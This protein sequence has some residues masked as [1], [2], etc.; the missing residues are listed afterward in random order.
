MPFVAQENQRAPGPRLSFRLPG[1]KSARLSLVDQA[2]VSGSNFLTTIILVRALGLSLF[3]QFS[4]LWLVVIFFVALQQA[5]LGQPLLTFAPKQDP[6]ER[7]A[8][9]AST[10]RLSLMFS[11]L[12]A[13]VTI[14]GYGFYLSRWG[15]PV[16]DGTF[17]PMVLLVTARQAHAYLRSACFACGLRERAFWNDLVTY[18][19]QPLVLA[20]LWFVGALTLANAMWVIGLFAALGCAVGI[21]NYEGRSTPPQPLGTVA[22]KHWKFSRWIAV[23]AIAQWFGTNSY[24]VATAAILGTNAVGA[25]KAAH[26][27]IGVLHLVFLAMENVVPVSA[28]KLLHAHGRPG[29]LRYMQRVARIGLLGTVAISACLMLFPETILSI[30][31]S[32]VVTEQ[33]VVA[34][35][36]LALMY[37]FVFLIAVL[38][39]I[40]RTLERTQVVFMTYLASTLV[41][42][43]L[44]EPIVARFGFEGAIYGM[45]GQQAFLAVLLTGMWWLDQRK[46]RLL[47]SA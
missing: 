24:L 28:A 47:P 12:L 27:V 33:L 10:L 23:M 45:V 21:W 16:M 40:F 35:R 1:S 11:A 42:V 13:L 18:P 44:A 4:M 38:N 9:L 2:L 34:M 17:W 31:Y 19:G 39:I 37:V 25:F 29:M 30:I 3:G 14:A 15:T 8:Y 5:L 7:D 32:G 6:E 20:A 22:R 26:T 41:A 43:A 36:G 46:A